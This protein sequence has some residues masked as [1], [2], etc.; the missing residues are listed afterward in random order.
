MRDYSRSK[1]SVNRYR[2]TP[3]APSVTSLL[4]ISADV[5]TTDYPLDVLSAIMGRT[6]SAPA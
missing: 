2:D 3:S 6:R 5:R 1:A 4:G